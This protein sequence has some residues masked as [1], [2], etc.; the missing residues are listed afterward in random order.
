MQLLSLL[1]A[2]L[3]L[4]STQVD[5]AVAVAHADINPPPNYDQLSDEEKARVGVFAEM[6]RGLSKPGCMCKLNKSLCGLR[7]SPRDFFLDLKENLEAGGLQ[8]MME[9]NPCLF[10]SNK[11]IC[12]MCVDDCIMMSSNQKEIDNVIDALPAQNVELEWEDDVAFLGVHIECSGDH[13]KLTQK[14]LIKRIV[15]ALHV[16]DLPAVATPSDGALG[17]DPE[18]DPPDCTFNYASIVG[19][20]WCPHN[21]SSPDLGFAVSQAAQFLFAPKHSHELALMRIGQCLNGTRDQGLTMKPMKHDAFEM[22][23]CMDLDFLGLY[24]KE[25]RDDPDNVKSQTGHVILLNRCPVIWSSHPQSSISV[26]TMMAECH[27]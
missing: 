24:G 6:P 4:A 9:V 11:V 15:E 21:H 3:D 16:E 18:G 5:C 1:M 23:A 25:D 27:A 20:S 8:S 2:Q 12:L 10:I 7:Q 26:S 17:K 14:G 22:D 13:V 19:V